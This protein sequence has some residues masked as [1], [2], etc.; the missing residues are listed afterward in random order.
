MLIHNVFSCRCH[1][2]EALKFELSSPTASVSHYTQE[3]LTGGTNTE[4]IR[5]TNTLPVAAYKE[6]SI[7]MNRIAVLVPLNPAARSYSLQTE[8]EALSH[9]YTPTL[10]SYDGASAPYL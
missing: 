8:E 5:R 10:L 7:S 3:R 9:R 6:T 2:S 4:I 1:R